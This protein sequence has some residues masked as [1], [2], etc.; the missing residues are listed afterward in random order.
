M[1]RDQ[2]PKPEVVLQGNHRVRVQD[3]RKGSLERRMIEKWLEQRPEVIHIK[4]KEES[5]TILI[6]L[7]E[8]GGRRGRFVRA[9]KDKLHSTLSA[10]KVDA[11]D[12]T[13]VHSLHGRV[14]VRI[15]GADCRQI[16]ALAAKAAVRPGVEKIIH[17]PGSD[18]VLIVYNPASLNEESILET[19]RESGLPEF[20]DEHAMPTQIRWGGAVAGTSVLLMCLSRAFPMPVMAVGI[21]LVALRPMRR[22][23]DAL[24]HEGKLNIDSL[25]VAATFAALGTGR[26]ATA[27]FVIWMVGVGDLLLDLSANSARN[28]LSKLVRHKES[29]ACVLLEDGSF[30]RVPVDALEVG[31]R[32]VVQAGQ[33]IAADGRVIDGR[34]EVDEK[35]LT[36][37]PRLIHKEKGDPV[38]AST[39]VIQGRIIL[40]VEVSARDTEAAKIER[41]LST[42]GNKPLTLQREALEFGGKLVP[43]TFAV[44]G[45]AA[46]LASNVTPGVSVL[47]TDFGTGIRIAVPTSALTAMTL[48]ARAGVMVKGAQYLER[49]SKTDVIIFDKTGTLTSGEPEVVEVLTVN[50][51]DKA[52]LIML[53]ASAEAFQ[54]HPVAKALRGY[55]KKTGIQLVDP[56][57]GSEEYAVGL[58][59]SARV[60]NHCVQ[61]G[62]AIWME[63]QGLE[64][65]FFRKDLARLKE[66]QISTLCVAVDGRLVGVIGYSDGT[67]P[68]SASIV[69]QLRANGRRKVVLL[70]G[71]NDEVV[72]KIAREVG[73]DEALG[74][75]LPEQK[76][77]YVRKLKAQGH[78]V[79][80]VGDGINDAPALAL[81]DV[82][83]S[84]AGSAE[85][86]LETADVV[87]LEGGL[88]RLPKAFALSE[89]AMTSVKRNLGVIIA[90]N[91][92]AIALGAFGFI[93]P[94][95][96]AV[97]N[98]GATMLAVSISTLPLLWTPKTETATRAKSEPVEGRFARL[99]PRRRLAKTRR[100]FKIQTLRRRG[101]VTRQRKVTKKEQAHVVE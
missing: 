47:V 29:E 96:A 69:S 26:P 43:P 73:I 68:E 74:S 5:E 85:V 88:T 3:L 37:E 58:G 55:A 33:G 86:A 54:E 63:E 70:S 92:V 44:A 50:G 87:L 62:R 61:V 1:N 18:T 83:I 17:L 41:V 36:G 56:E 72:Q 12:V 38:F 40:E 8:T 94:P 84:I 51:F 77:D 46:T 30:R 65:S 53:S 89:Q 75:L 101:P 71:D 11:F 78:V 31:D 34:A 90:P 64:V 22:S 99:A 16:A 32:I 9:L 10:E 25:D 45:V 95:I 15:A 2:H 4:A 14:R 100:F 21:T 93:T 59:L 13:L 28:A 91:A 76:A 23:A 42:L 79:A 49:L 52:L 60:N 24:I 57:P 66:S 98:N 20:P 27:A 7:D 19:L 82:G 67:R 81:A 97:I 35:S 48:A 6:H 80:M 39:L